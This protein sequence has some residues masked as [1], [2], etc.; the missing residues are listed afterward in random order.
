M[1]VGQVLQGS[2]DGIYSSGRKYISLLYWWGKAVPVWEC[3]SLLIFA[4]I[5][6]W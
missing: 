6:L 2:V 5:N 3:L 1:Q 4:G